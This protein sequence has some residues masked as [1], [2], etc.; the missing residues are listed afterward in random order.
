MHFAGRFLTA[1]A[2]VLLLLPRPVSAQER[3][4]GLTGTVTDTSGAVLPGATVNITNKVS[5]A[6]KSVVTSDDGLYNVQDLDPGRY[7]VSIELSG[8]AKAEIAEVNIS[9]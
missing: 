2:A 7:A 8:F 6:V 9:L 4:G 5:G 3:F 1:A